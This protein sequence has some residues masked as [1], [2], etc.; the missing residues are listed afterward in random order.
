MSLLS[1]DSIVLVKHESLNISIPVRY[2]RKIADSFFFFFKSNQVKNSHAMELECLQK[3]LTF[4]KKEIKISHLVT[5]RH[6]GIKAHMSKKEK[7]IVH[8]FDIW[9]MAK[10]ISLILKYCFN[11]F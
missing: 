4:L 1:I 10:G 11:N 5:D 8:A 6:T 9:H 2:Y 7:D 3:G